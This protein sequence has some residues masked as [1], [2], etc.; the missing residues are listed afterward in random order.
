MFHCLCWHTFTVV[1]SS[2][3][4][5]AILVCRGS[6]LRVGDFTHHPDG[7][8]IVLELAYRD[9]P[10][11]VVNAYLSAKGTAKEYRR[12][13]HWLRA[14]VAPD[15]RLVL[16]GRDFPS[17]PGSSADCVSIHTEIAPFL[18]EFAADMHPVPFTHGMRGPTGVSAQGFVGALGFF[19]SRRVSVDIGVVRV[20]SELVFLS[21][22]YPVRLRLLTSLA[23][24]APGNPTA[25]ARF[26]LRSHVFQWQR[27]AFADSC[28]GLHSVPPAATPEAYRH[29]VS[30]MTMAAEAVF[31]LP[32]VPDTVP[33]LVSSAAKVLHALVK[34]HPRWWLNAPLTRK[35]LVESKKVRRRGT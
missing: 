14:H 31:G 7:T 30:V 34:A 32:T 5:V 11:H 29:F 22:H 16:L 24:V 27:E 18:L 10:V 28:T 3:A 25:R 23:L 6:Q 12:L 33:G 17:N 13:L 26:K 35:V 8:A 19:L 15:S 1:S 20:E 9:T 21:D 4:G 2:S